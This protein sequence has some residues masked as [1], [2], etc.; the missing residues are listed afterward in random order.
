MIAYIAA[1]L[2]QGVVTVVGISIVVFAL[3]RVSG[4]PTAL[5]VP[6]EAT[7]A[8]R[9]ATRQSFGLDRP[10]PDQYIIFVKNALR[11]DFGESVQF[12]E[13]PAGLFW[14]RF[15]NTLQLAG[16]A[17]AAALISGLSC[18]ALAAMR[19]GSLT[20]R[21][22]GLVAVIGQALPPFLVAVV[23][24]L[25]LAVEFGWLPV[26]GKGGPATFVMPVLS[27][28]W[29]SMAGLM[30]L[31]RGSLIEVL[32]SDYV[33]CARMKGLP[34]RVVVLRHALPAALVP[35]ISMFSVHI[36]FFVSGSAVVETIFAWPGI[37]QLTIQAV[38]ARDY[39][40]LQAIVFFTS[41]FVVAIGVALTVLPY[42]FRA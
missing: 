33:R 24:I 12:D 4:D 21:A 16:V 8:Q 17:A 28:A 11:G 6:P 1:R 32:R 26:S 15:P 37:G 30:R 38:L 22:A 3:A 41:L 29:F 40:L 35:L 18:G 5:L 34:E 27:L 7:A 20:D 36:A 23:M 13:S 31:T 9:E 25:V 2:A 10:L 42:F 39:P 19:P 14:R